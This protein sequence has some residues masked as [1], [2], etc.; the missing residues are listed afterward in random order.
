MPW[1]HPIW[2]SSWVSYS[3]LIISSDCELKKDCHFYIVH[4]VTV[5]PDW[6]LTILALMSSV[7]SVSSRMLVV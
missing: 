4:F 6:S 1:G 5:I 2:I 3:T 7:A